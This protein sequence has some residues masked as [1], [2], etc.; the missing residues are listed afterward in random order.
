MRI[1]AALAV[2][3]LFLAVAFSNCHA[4]EV[5][6]KNLL[7][8]DAS[9]TSGGWERWF[10]REGVAPEL[11]E[12]A[13]GGGTLSV[14]GAGIR[15]SIGGWQ[16]KI[17]DFKPGDEFI[18]RAEVEGRE[19]ANPLGN[20]WIRIYWS[21]DLP[22]GTAPDVVKL[23]KTGEGKYVF[24]DRV[25]VPDGAQ[26]AIV[27]LIYRWEPEG[28]AI[29]KNISLKPAGPEKPHRKVRISTIYWRPTGP[30]TVQNNFEN[31]LR[32]IDKAAEE[33]PDLILV[34]EGAMVVG[35]GF[36]DMDAVSEELPGG[37]FF[38]AFAEKAKKH[39][40]HVCYG[41]YERDGKFVFNTAVLI[42]PQGEIAGKYRKVHLPI[43]ED[44]AGLAPGNSFNVFETALGRIGMV[45]C[46]D[47]TFTESVHCVALK[48]AEIVLVPIWGGDEEM[49]R[50]RA[51]EDGVYVVTSSFDMKCMIVDPHGKVLAATFKDL[52]TGVATAD[53]DLD[54]RAK[55][56]W[57]GDFRSYKNRMRRPDAYGVIGEKR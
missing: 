20:L 42:N 57:T 43:E 38:T 27:R 29:W 18:V 14:S 35:V 48:G 44:V 31:W 50:V 23:H 34:G 24:E 33:K 12:S 10:P 9:K 30:T 46:F 26:S 3:G 28:T 21:G 36:G 25:R 55:E 2:G 8:Y 47:T 53:C 17:T 6:M 37:K 39:G 5:A 13:E 49:V 11:G 56:P 4:Q 40:C 16:R 19:L 1:I 54:D 52:G 15:Y 22:M 51:K 41:T 7:G 32:M 45:I